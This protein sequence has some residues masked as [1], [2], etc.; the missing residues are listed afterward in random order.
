MK[1]Y[2]LAVAVMMC[3][4]SSMAF[5]ASPL[6]E[7]VNTVATTN[8]Y[9][10]IEV[11]ALPKAVQDAIKKDHANAIIKEA[12]VEEKDGVKTYKVVLTAQ[13]GTEST[14]TYNE[15]GEAQK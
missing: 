15:K 7:S 12:S 1:K 9:T 14:V 2:F 10:P 11:S 5:A 6:T 4:G 8:D 13:D 3:M